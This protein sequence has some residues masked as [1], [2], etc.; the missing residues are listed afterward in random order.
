MI[1]YISLFLIKFRFIKLK[2][3]KMENIMP[4]KGQEKN[5]K[6]MQTEIEN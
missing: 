5:L 4:S 3:K 1:N 2:A 6:V